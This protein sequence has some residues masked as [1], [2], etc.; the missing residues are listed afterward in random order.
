MALQTKR[1]GHAVAERG[2]HFSSK[3]VFRM[4]PFPSQFLKKEKSTVP[5]KAHGVFVLLKKLLR[6]RTRSG[7]P[8]SQTFC[9]STQD[10]NSEEMG[11][12]Y[13]GGFKP[14]TGYGS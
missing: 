5:D 9:L 4:V 8:D 2:A 10:R 12:P 1:D 6:L 13:R 3:N 11:D 14:W 7:R